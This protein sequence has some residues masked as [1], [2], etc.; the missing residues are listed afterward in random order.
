M[1]MMIMDQRI[2]AMN[3]IRDILSM[4]LAPLQYMVSWPIQWIDHA[5]ADC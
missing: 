4:P 5:R 1:T 2:A 3:K